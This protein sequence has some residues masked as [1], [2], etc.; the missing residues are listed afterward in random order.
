VK[1][2]KTQIMNILPLR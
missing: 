1:P 2:L